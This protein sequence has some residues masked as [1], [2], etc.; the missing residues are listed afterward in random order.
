MSTKPKL[1]VG[2]IG[3][4]FMGKAHVF[5]YATAAQVFDLPFEIELH[6]LADVT[7]A[8][9]LKAAARLRLRA[10][11]F[12]LDGRSFA[13]PRSTSSTS[14]RRTLFMKRWRLAAIAAGKH[15]YC[16]KPL[17]PLAVEAARRMAEAAEAA[18]DTN[19]GRI[20]LSMQPHAGLRTRDDRGPANSVKSEAIAASTARTTWPTLLAPTLSGTIRPVAARSPISVHMHS[21]LPSSCWLRRRSDHR[22]HGRLRHRDRR[23]VRTASGGAA[24]ST[25]DDIGS[26]FLRFASGATGS[27]EATGSPPAARCSTTSKSGDAGRAGLQPGAF[28]RA[29]FLLGRRPAADARGFRRIEAGP[30]HPP[31]G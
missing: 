8:A 26:A 11:D 27:I 1:R 5:G 13:T 22:R 30:D 9:A 18:G 16:E 29:A 2:L 21:P 4:G 19:A 20:Q 14:P 17:A 24:P 15:V 25:V 10:R 31:Y 12:G 23:S 7:E 3:S 28:E 6:T